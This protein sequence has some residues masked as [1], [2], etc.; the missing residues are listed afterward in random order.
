MEIEAKASDSR[1]RKVEEEGLYLYFKHKLIEFDFTCDL[2]QHLYT[3]VCNYKLENCSFDWGQTFEPDLAEL[4]SRSILLRTLTCGISRLTITLK[5]AIDADKNLEPS[6]MKWESILKKYQS[7]S[8]CDILNMSN[9]KQ[10]FTLMG[11]RL[12][13]P[14]ADPIKKFQC[15]VTLDFATPKIL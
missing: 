13:T 10:D 4:L 11:D 15:R 9:N 2:I 1:L 6:T 14:G 12:E 7:L 5:A 3:Q 8:T